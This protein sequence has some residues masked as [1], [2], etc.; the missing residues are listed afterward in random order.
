[1]R[2]RGCVPRQLVAR[3]LGA[4]SS[5]RERVAVAEK[6][7]KGGGH[8]GGVARRHDDSRLVAADHL[9]E[10]ADVVDDRRHTC[11][12]SLQERAGN[13]DLGP[14]RKQGDRRIRERAAELRVGQVAETPLRPVAG[15]SLQALERHSRIADDEQAGAV[16]AEDSLDG[17]FRSLVRP[18]Q[19][20]AKR[21]PSVVAAVELRP[22]HRV[23]D[24]SY[25][26]LGKPEV[27][28]LAPAALGVHDDAR[29]AVE[30]RSPHRGLRERPPRDDVVSGEDGRT[31]WPEQPA[32]ELGH[33]EPLHV[34][35]VG[36]REREA[37]HPERVLQRFDGQASAASAHA[38]REWIEPLARRVAEGR[39]DLAETEARRH[40]L[41]VDIRAGERRGERAV[42]RR[43][44]G[45]RV[46]DDDTHG[47][48][49]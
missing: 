6:P 35:H 47:G 7:R 22:E 30:E 14:V 39:R 29:E 2:G 16:D 31:S 48:E 5:D 10:T 21:G 46:G 33:S 4:G 1:M 8:R 36:L 43:R 40:E 49:R 25:L 41:D 19:P 26:V 37:R 12:E 3:A 17:V 38:R 28:E 9:A 34:D 11:A 44:V 18:D 23:A 27:D 13:V 20:K 45:G 24:H 32:V 42:V 15:G